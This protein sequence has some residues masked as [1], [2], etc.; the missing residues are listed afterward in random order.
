MS[1]CC[2]AT[3]TNEQKQSKRSLGEMQEHEN[4]LL[5]RNFTHHTAR[6]HRQ[7]E[8][9]ELS[10]RHH[11]AGGHLPYKMATATI[12]D[13]MTQPPPHIYR[14]TI[15]TIIIQAAEN[16]CHSGQIRISCY[17]TLGITNS[18]VHV[19]KEKQPRHNK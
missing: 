2:R 5:P 17:V 9:A 11:T 8:A 14:C 6:L 16:I 18:R 7:Y 4:I 3:Q 10:L 19:F 13:S 12:I 1:P 15:S